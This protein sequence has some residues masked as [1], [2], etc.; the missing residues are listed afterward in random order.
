MKK[1]RIP[2]TVGML[3]VTLIL[4]PIFGAFEAHIINVV[5]KIENGVIAVTPSE[6][7]FGTVFPQ[8]KLE[9]TFAVSLSNTL[10]SE[11]IGT[12]YASF[13]SGSTQDLRKNGTAVL[14]NRSDPT[15]TLGAPE[16]SGAPFDSPVITGTFFSLG[17][18]GNVVLG[19]DDFIV[20]T[21]GD[22]ITVFEV[23]GGSS[24]P[25]EDATV[26]ASQDGASWTMLG[27]VT[28]DG[29]V[30]LGAMPW[31]KFVRIIDI[32]DPAP[33]EST[34][35]RSEEHTSELQSH[36]FISYAVFCLKKKNFFSSFPGHSLT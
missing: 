30:D 33:F 10:L 26:E 28:R 31:A 34:A 2:F 12:Q 6:I 25:E 23:T 5:A 14:A 21:P 22:D 32:S 13:V 36:S 18:G 19:F 11:P 35:D 4:V 15:E 7:S 8:E 24:Y 29:S 1:R 16:S 9:K 17:F 3:A 20:N 27:T